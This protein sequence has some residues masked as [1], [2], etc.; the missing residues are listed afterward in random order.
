MEIVKAKYEKEFEHLVSQQTKYNLKPIDENPT[1]KEGKLKY[2]EWIYEENIKLNKRQRYD[3]KR[4]L[5][6][7]DCSVYITP[8]LYKEYTIFLNNKKK[9]TIFEQIFNYFKIDFF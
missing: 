1:T 9:P 7:F 8:H 3:E 4:K 2:F 5:L 6:S